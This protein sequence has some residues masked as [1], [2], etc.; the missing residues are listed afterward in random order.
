M[1]ALTVKPLEAG[2]ARVEE[3]PDPEP[4]DGELLVRGVAVGIC[5]T[6]KEIVAGEYGWAPPGSERLVLGHES[7]GRVERAPAGS[8]FSEGDLVAGVVTDVIE[9]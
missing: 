7:L 3:V 2:S 1:R 6:D 8:G 4:G 9:L 5:G